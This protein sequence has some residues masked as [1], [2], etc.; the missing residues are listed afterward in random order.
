MDE[1]PSLAQIWFCVPHPMA[2]LP[3]S[4]LHC[5]TALW[6]LST[7]WVLYLLKSHRCLQTPP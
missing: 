4:M 3:N 2:S 6:G 1:M 7:G 5:G